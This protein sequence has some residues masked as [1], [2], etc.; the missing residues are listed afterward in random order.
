MSPPRIGLFKRPPDG[1]RNLKSRRSGAW[2][3]FHEA[4]GKPQRVRHEHRPDQPRVIRRETAIVLRNADPRQLAEA[5]LDAQLLGAVQGEI[6]VLRLLA[7]L[8]LAS[9]ADPLPDQEGPDRQDL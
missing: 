3:L 8:H 4:Q 1:S 5:D 2:R 7:R 6:V 9:D